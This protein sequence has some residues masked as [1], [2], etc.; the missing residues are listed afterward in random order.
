MRTTAAAL[1]PAAAMALTLGL[2]APAFAQGGA[3]QIPPA[4]NAAESSPN[5]ANSAPAGTLTVSPGAANAVNPSGG[6]PTGPGARTGTAA[7]GGALRQA[8]P[9]PSPSSTGTGT[10]R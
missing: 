8:V 9:Q 4:P 3:T 2:A 1:S 5:P 10:T 7:S 6:S